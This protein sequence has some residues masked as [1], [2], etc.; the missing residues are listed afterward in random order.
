LFVVAR[1]STFSYKGKPVKVQQVAEEL[2]VRYV[3]EGSV[4]KAEDRVRITAQLIDALTG[5]HLWAEGYD[6]ELKDILA[7]QGEITKEI[8]T[9]LQ[10]QLTKG[11]QARVFARGTDNVEA[12]A[13]GAKAWRFFAKTTKENNAKARQLMERGIKLDPDYALLWTHLGGTHLLDARFGWTKSR[14]E[15]S[16][17][18]VECTKKALTLDEESPIAHSMMANIYLFQ[19][20]YER[21][22]AEGER[23]I[24][25]DPN[26]AD[27]YARLAQ[28][29]L[30][31]GRFEE[32]LTLIKKAMRLCPMPRVWYPV[33][34]GQAYN[35]LERYEEAIP[36][37]K[38]LLERCRRGEC[39]PGWAQRGLIVSY[40][41]LGRE[42]EARAVAKE[43]LRV[44]PKYSLERSRKANF[45]KDPAHLEWKLSALRKAGIPETPPLPLPD[46]PSI[47]VLPFVNMSGDPEQEYFSDGITEEIITALSKTPKLFVIA[48]NSTFTYKNKP[49][50]VQK[51]GREL[52]VKYVLEGSVRKAGNKVRVT[53]QLV[54][55][56]TGHHL[57]AERYDRKMKDIFAIQD[58]ITKNIITEVQVQLTTGEQARL[59][60]KGTE[61]LDAYLKYLKASEYLIQFN[62][63]DS[64]RA[65]KLAEETIALDPSFQK[66]Y[67]ILAFVEIVD[68]WVGLSKSPKESLMRAMELA[69]K[70]IAIDDSPL[71]HRVLATAYVLFRKHDAAIAEARKAIQM[72]PNYAAAYMTLGHVLMLSD[73]AEEAIPVLE[74][75]IR[76][77]PYPP[78]PYFHNLAFSY[79]L[80]GKYEEAISEAKKAIRV[81]PK[82][83]IAHRALVSCYSFLG[84]EDEAHAQAAEVLRI[85]P[86]F[87][88][89]RAEKR[90][91]I[92]NKDKVKKIF[93]SYRKAGL[94]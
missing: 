79:I 11:E 40:I 71:P 17:R 21:G 65:R 70:S 31:S 69:K 36:V 23:A 39:P 5:H 50:K 38:Q 91:P 35:H 64:I 89:D 86:D 12:W 77:N 61:N 44:D 68:V 27:G 22:I 53:A 26:Y 15:S 8:I 76:L 42:E 88:V 60:A 14:A 49:T 43:L 25:V 57:W 37:L 24:S 59:R 87:S 80:L 2:G 55:A 29:M 78:S 82:D 93:D 94:K 48:R 33:I 32:A 45:Y 6:R 34:L 54:D 51:V 66:G 19:R 4:R 3:L 30:Y 84:R 72:A 41:R 13:L 20:Q 58:N 46:K 47:A 81:S 52:G 16:K 67:S 9:A 85:D 18:G 74:K 90:S 75:A 1:Q 63:E 10:V 56:Q 92:K 62:K 28:V 73:M 83:I 7:L